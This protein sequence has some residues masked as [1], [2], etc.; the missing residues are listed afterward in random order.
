[1]HEGLRQYDGGD[2]AIARTKFE[3]VVAANPGDAR[4]WF[5]LGKAAHQLG[6]MR[7]CIGGTSKSIELSESEQ[8]YLVPSLRWRAMCH[9]KAGDTAAALVDMQRTTTIAP[10]DAMLWVELSGLQCKSG[11][12]EDCGVSLRQARTLTGGK[13]QDVL[14]RINDLVQFI[15]K[16]DAACK[17]RES[18]R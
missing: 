14:T 5:F 8:R 12:L 16:D 1:M 2:M 7:G 4:A 3:E 11:A 18:A 10:G 15:C 6:D 17:A 9:D 13:N